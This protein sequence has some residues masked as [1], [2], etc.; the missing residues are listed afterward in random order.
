M[1]NN[2][3]YNINDKYLRIDKSL[4]T[5]FLTCPKLFKQIIDGKIAIPEEWQIVLGSEFHDKVEMFWRNVIVK[6]GVLYIPPL[7]SQ[8]N[9]LN[10]IYEN[11]KKM[12]MKRW[13]YCNG[14]LKKFFPL[15]VEK[16]FISKIELNDWTIEL[17]GKVDMIDMEDDND[18]NI[19]IVEWKTGKPDIKHKVELDFYNLLLSNLGFNVSEGVVYYP[20]YDEVNVYKLDEEGKSEI[21]KILKTIIYHLEND[22][23]YHNYDCGCDRN[24]QQ[25]SP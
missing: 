19:I 5:S 25:I 14:D 20:K 7:K 13:E 8:N 24:V 23:W 3:H 12:V 4:L 22:I 16:K 9:Y 21:I 1:N 18:K 17:V 6:D 10:K 2:Q 11:F 15:F